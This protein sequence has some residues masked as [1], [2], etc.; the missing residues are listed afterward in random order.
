MS[1]YGDT[2]DNLS[3]LKQRFANFK[4][5]LKEKWSKAHRKEAIFL[6]INEAWLE[7]TF[8]LSGQKQNRPGRPSKSFEDSSERTKRRK[9][10]DM[11]SSLSDKVIVHAA[12]TT[13][14]AR[15]KRDASKILREITNSPTR[16]GKYRKAYRKSEREEITS[17]TPLQA[18][19]MFVEADLTKRQYEI[20]RNTNKSFYPCY[21]LLLKAKKECYPAE[22]SIR[23]TSTCAESNLQSLIDNTVTRLSMALEGILCSLKDNERNTLKI[24]C[25]W[26]CD[27]SQQAKY[28]QQF[29]DDD[30]SD[31]NVFL[32][33]FVPLRITCGKE[34]K[35]IIWENPTPSSPRYCRPI[36]FRFVKE[37]TAV[38]K[39]E[40]SYVDESAKKLTPTEVTLNGSKLMFEHVFKMTMIDGKVCNA[41][42]DTKSTSRCYI[43]GAT[44]KD[45]NNLTQKLNTSST[46]IE[47]GLSVLHAR[48]RLF[49]SVLHLAYKLPVKKYREKRTNEEMELEDRQK[50]HIQERF[51]KETGLLV[52][53]PK[54]NFGNTNNGNTSR[55]FFE[56]PQ[57]AADI[58]K[59]DFELIYR[60]K[61]IL[62]TISSGHKID[63]QQFDDYAMA[64]A[65]LYVDLYEWHPMTPTMHKILIHGAAV[66]ENA[67]LPIGQLSEEAA[68]ARNK[69]F[70][71]YR[72]NY[73]R[74]FSREECNRDVYNRLLLSSDPLLSSM[75]QTK[76]NKPRL[77]CPETI[78]MLLP[79]DPTTE[80]DFSDTDQDLSINE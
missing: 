16:A 4:T 79:A 45:F 58:T 51:R 68:E 17:L 11:R 34:G 80:S 7:G 64:T 29:D 56:N 9:T 22:D 61:V 19:S 25:K 76:K 2:P 24:I 13:L 32:S 54:V 39:Q 63:V 71:L 78:N 35:K 21:D 69:H 3:S 41:A 6:K 60:L 36:R 49:E 48:I 31:A 73:A 55:R 46:A 40:I 42:T 10:E 74:K 1:S 8:V 72:E 43:C 38:I 70:R 28:T 20:I 12:Q 65:K 5:S 50:K 27:G 57:L 67:L 53:M 30:A 52:D 66:I 59:I 14:Q 15:G 47:F 37:S 26:G 75:K 62:E 44:S 77:F 23:V 33:S 18:L